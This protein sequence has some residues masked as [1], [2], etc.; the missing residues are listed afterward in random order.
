MSLYGQFRGRASILR[1]LPLRPRLMKRGELG[2][3]R[4]HIKGLSG[5]VRYNEVTLI[6][7]PRTE[8]RDSTTHVRCV[9]DPIYL[10]PMPNLSYLFWN[11]RCTFITHLAYSVLKHHTYIGLRDVFIPIHVKS[12]VFSN[13]GN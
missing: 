3:P 4:R 13:V 11:I 12:I 7:R 6:R 8:P 9:F 1:Y 10:N 5:L 2:V